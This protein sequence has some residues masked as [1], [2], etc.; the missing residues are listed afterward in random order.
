MVDVFSVLAVTSSE[1]SAVGCCC[2][3]VV[4]FLGISEDVSIVAVTLRVLS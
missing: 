3:W 1:M 4:P 2:Y